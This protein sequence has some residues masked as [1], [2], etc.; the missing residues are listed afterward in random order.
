[1]LLYFMNFSYVSRD[2]L[3]GRGLFHAT[4]LCKRSFKWVSCPLLFQL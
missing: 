1:L 3:R 4:G 2:I